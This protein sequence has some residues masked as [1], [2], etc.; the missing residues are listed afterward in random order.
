M[1]PAFETSADPVARPLAPG[2]TPPA[3]ATNAGPAGTGT[4]LGRGPIEEP[5][6]R[7]GYPPIVKQPAS[8][9]PA[10]MQKLLDGDQPEIK[11]RMRLLLAQPAFRYYAGTDTPGLRDKVFGWAKELAR[12]GIGA[13]FMPR[14]AGGEEDIGKFMAAFEILGFHDI[15]L[16]IKFGVQFGLWGGSILRL[17]TARHHEKYLPATATLDLPGCF[18]MTEIGHGSNVKDL[19][20]VAVY[21]PKTGE[22]D[23]HSPTFFSGKNYIGNAAVHGRIATVFAQLETRGERHGVHAFVV[24]IRGDDGEPLP[25][26]RIEDNSQKL[27]LN[28]VDNGRIWFDHVRVPRA[29]LLDRFA[30]VA[31]DGTYSSQIKNPAARFFTTIGTLVGGRISVG[32]SGNSAAKS[33]LAIAIRYGARRRQFG[34][35]GTKTETLLLDYPAHQRRL[36]PLLANAYALDFAFKHLT[37][38]NLT[39]A[40]GDYR[41][42]ETMAAGLKAFSTWNMTHTLQTG[43]EACGGEGFLAVNR[44]AALKGDSDVFTTF[45]GDNTILMQLVA[46]NLLTDFKDSFKGKGA[47]QF[48]AFLVSQKAK[49]L[50]ARNPLLTH[51]TSE[52]HL[53]DPAVQLGWFHHREETL[54]AALGGELRARIGRGAEAYAAFT[55]LQNELLQLAFAWT[56]RIILEQFIHTVRVCPDRSLRPALKRLCDL[57]ALAHLE[58]NR[59]WFL[60]NGVF[61]PAK[62]RAITAL[63]DALCAEV[64][65]EAVALVDAFGIP[66]ECLAAPIALD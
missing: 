55:A 7:R 46:K 12:Q 51:K 19:E 13:L 22:F 5:W 44:F 53:R 18:A 36:M 23:L 38:L 21:D 59:A 57:F 15:S 47:A 28:G 3:P 16:V 26:I 62:S 4:R 37:K 64:R 17:G 34:P 30:Q 66:P 10:A 9:D 35:P 43:R 11:A 61:A 45:E 25:G 20:T 49:A 6:T 24:P 52:S 54:L 1:P 31:A 14:F 48:A 63:V 39:L 33:G 56:E 60:E 42:V 32:A 65:Q 8:F 40:T 50:A 27:G 2:E 58:K 41:R 29:E